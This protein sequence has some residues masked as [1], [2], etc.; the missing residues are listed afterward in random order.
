MRALTSIVA[1]VAGAALT[2][3][4]ARADAYPQYQLSRDQTCA[5]CHLSPAGGG[6]LSENGYNVAE[7]TSQFGTAPEFMYGKVPQPSWLALG[8]DLRGSTGEVV[9]PDTAFVLFPMQ[10]DVYV[11]LAFNGFSL[12]LTGGA[13]PAQWITNNGTPGI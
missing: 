8:G 10:A 6:S 3:L 1:G 12:H 5:G 13:R 11:H 2:L 9:T 4:G 7:A